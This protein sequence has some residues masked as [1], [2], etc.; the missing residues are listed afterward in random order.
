V[1][2]TKWAVTSPANHITSEPEV[3][4][5]VEKHIGDEPSTLHMILPEVYLG[6]PDQTDAPIEAQ[7]TMKNYLK[8][9]YWQPTTAS[10]SKERTINEKH[11]EASC[12]PSTLNT[13]ISQRDLKV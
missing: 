12:R 9:D 10:S 7:N 13:M 3:L 6:H 4:E 5:F 1:N 11:D 8:T 2:L